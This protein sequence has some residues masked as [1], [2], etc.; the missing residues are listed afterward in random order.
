MILARE[1]KTFA[2]SFLILLVEGVG[3]ESYTPEQ[4]IAI[5]ILLSIVLVILFVA[6][7]ILVLYIINAASEKR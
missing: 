2:F 4:E 6:A 3:V 1:F 7:I 5:F